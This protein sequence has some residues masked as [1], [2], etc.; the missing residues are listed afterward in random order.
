MRRW[1]WRAFLTLFLLAGLAA[2]G[3]AWWTWRWLARPY[4]GYGG[5][6]I[7]DV[8]PGQSASGILARLEQQGI[9][10]NAR[11]ARAYLVYLLG[12]PPLL[13]G[14]Y[15]FDRPLTPPQVLD[16]LIRGE[17]VTYRLTLIEGLTLDEAADA[18][19]AQGFG[20]PE[21]LRR[22]MGRSDLIADL[23][24]EAPDLEGYLHPDTY[25]FARGIS[26]AE[27]IATLVATFR[28]RFHREV[29]PLA[30]G[31]RTVR[32]LIALASIVEKETQADGERPLI[33]GVFA[34]RLRRGMALGADPTVIYALK[35]E[36][37]W[38][39]NLRRSDLQLD[40]PYN[41]YLYPGLPPGPICS[42][43]LASLIAAAKPAE[44]DYLYFVSRNDGTH[45]FATNLRDHNN[46]VH[47]WQRRYWQRR[48]AEERSG[49]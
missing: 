12:D 4:Q 42:P 27:I 26:E 40:S 48:W 19:A 20:D 24:P 8:R 36:G 29:L 15:R 3:A 5:E 17:V 32:E 44:T 22:E 31:S 7:V 38:D 25:H 11:L 33:A 18:L 28:Q 23:D 49:R 41:T 14:E 47:R 34:N 30:D 9:L 45:V 46:N 10:A 35:R 6:Q 2:A 1:F 37:V 21:V 39:G 43:G 16:K 13:A